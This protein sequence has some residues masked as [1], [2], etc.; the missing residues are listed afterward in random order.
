M[1]FK[2][3]TKDGKLFIFRKFLFKKGEGLEDAA[4]RLNAMGWD[5]PLDVEDLKRKGQEITR[6]Y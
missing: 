1:T 4:A 3:T 6:R 5:I 2:K